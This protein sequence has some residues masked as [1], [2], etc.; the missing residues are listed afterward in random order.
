[1][2]TK[3]VKAATKQLAPVYGAQEKA[4]SSQVPAIQ[5]LYNTLIQGLEQS[6]AQQLETGVTGIVEDASRRGVLRSTLPVDAR[7][8]L[9]AQLSQALLQGRGQLESQRAGD[10]AGINERLGSLRIQRTGN[11]ADLA[12]ALETRDLE[13]RQFRLQQLQA[14]RDYELQKQQL[15]ISRSNAARSSSPSTR[16]TPQWQV[17]QGAIAAWQEDMQGDKDLKYKG[18][19]GRGYLSP[20]SYKSYKKKWVGAGFKANDFDSNFGDYAN[21]THLWDYGIK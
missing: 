15:A 13:E 20:E 18:D 2:A 8:S 10:I 16:S 12:R 6:S 17:N 5:N 14:K 1:M 21:P 4:I 3:F 9:Q 19:Q 7:Q 11:I